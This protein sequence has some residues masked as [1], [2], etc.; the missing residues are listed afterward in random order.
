MTAPP[1]PPLPLRPRRLPGFAF[2]TRVPVPDEVLPRMDVAA[3]LGFAASGPVGVPVP[4]EDA[5]QFAAVFGADAPLAWDAALGR[6]VTAQLGPAVRAFFANGGR[7]CWVVRVARAPRTDRLPVP[8]V[9]VLAGGDALRGL[10]LAARAPGRWADGVA[11][12]TS[13]TSRRLGVLAW[14]GP[15]R[16]LDLVAPADVALAE[17]DL[18]RL[19]WRDPGVVL[20]LGVREVTA[21]PLG[22]AG[23]TRS[24]LHV[25]GGARQ[26]FD[27][28]REPATLLGEARLA[29]GPATARLV[30]AAASP[31][32]RD[33]PLTV[34]VDAPPERAPA[35][36][37]IVAVDFGGDHLVLAVTAVTQG[38]RGGAPGTPAL[39]V[40]GRGLWRRA[41][42]PWA[43]PPTDAPPS[44][45]RLTL[46]VWARLPGEVTR[47][48]GALGLAP[49]HA[50]HVEALPDDAAVYGADDARPDDAP[51]DLASW[52]DAIVPR[53]PAAGAGER[54]ADGARVTHLCIPLGVGTLP[55]EYLPAV[56]PDG[57]PLERDGLVPFDATLFADAA[58]ADSRTTTLL[59]DAEYLRILAPEPRPRLIGMHAL[60]PVDEVTLVAVPDAVQPGWDRPLHEARPD[61]LPPAPSDEG[62]VGF[63]A[64]LGPAPTLRAAAR[65][66]ALSIELA[67]DAAG[68]AGPF[69]VEES[70]DRQWNGAVE[71]YRGTARAVTLSPRRP[72][73][74][75]YRVRGLGSGGLRGTPWSVGVAVR[76]AADDGWRVR[77]PH[78]YA[79]DTLLTVHRLLL[80]LCAARRDVMAVLALPEHY[81]EDGAAAHA[82]LLAASGAA[83]VALSDGGPLVAPLGTGEADALGFA[84]L[85]HGWVYAR[86][87]DGT[88]RAFPPDGPACGV[89]ARRAIERGAWIAPANE[90]LRG[91]IALARPAAPGRWQALQQL[92]IDVV[93]QHPHGFVVLN[94]DTLAGD[95][96]LRPIGVRRLLILLRRLA[97]R[98][99]ATYVF[100]PND[101]SFRRTV[102]GSFEAMLGELFQRGA[103]AGRTEREAFRVVADETVN[104]PQSVER[105]RF[106]LELRV[107]PSRPMAFLTIRLVQTGDRVAV[108]G[109]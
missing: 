76:L 48:V 92:Q 33:A 67:W 53:F 70:L 22:R 98:R 96:D 103:F 40:T 80:R 29:G 17:G 8:G 28:V 79:N 10:A 15:D 37:E 57:A 107:A 95:D 20:Y 13:L 39:H 55:G 58:L 14:H 90:P 63:G 4:V 36:G 51:L 49:G 3:F 108:T 65:D 77:R 12:A 109:A 85:Y 11:L 62:D 35:V 87:E 104:T 99:G 38:A 52:A 54:D 25:W 86:D 93:R 88:V 60:L 81:R 21:H 61:P 41:D 43:S 94:A 16:M 89:I 75:Y 68:D 32:E 9:A 82:R 73:D 105:G 56:V 26:W 47:R 23:S 64:C 78:D 1:L 2:E 24:R 84:A 18:L 45:E 71:V 69:V 83:P 31:P 72:D 5:A 46:D 100:E 7:R 101:E 44:V 102:Q 19:A 106:I 74:Y 91:V 30:T 27:T 66:A 59:A 34:A 97:L 50:R 6:T 42:A